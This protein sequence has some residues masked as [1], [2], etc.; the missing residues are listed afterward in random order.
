VGLK[1]DAIDLFEVDDFGSITYGLEQRAHAQ[2]SGSA[3][4]ALA[5]A[6]DEVERFRGEG[7]YPRRRG[8]SVLMARLTSYG[9]SEVSS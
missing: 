1:Q 8:G 2:V 4:N 6:H 9:I 7:T 3:Q 5:G